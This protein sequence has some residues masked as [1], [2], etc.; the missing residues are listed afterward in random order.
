[1]GDQRDPETMRFIKSP[2][3]VCYRGTG[4]GVYRTIVR[5]LSG[6]EPRRSRASLL[7]GRLYSQLLDGRDRVHHTF[8]MT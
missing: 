2:G 5:E 8:L 1:M 4:Y 3:G 6:G 7:L